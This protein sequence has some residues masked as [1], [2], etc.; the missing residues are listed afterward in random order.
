ML[1]DRER[2]D[3][4]LIERQLCD[5]DPRLAARF[6]SL[7]RARPVRAPKT[8]GGRDGVSQ[9]SM[10]AAGALPC[11]L[12]AAGLIMLLAGAAAGAMAVV[13]AGVVLTVLTLGIAATSAPSRGAGFA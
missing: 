9:R 8:L 7:G 4:A 5:E 10:H 3:L 1:S 2:R 6:R 13:V 12:L 11:V